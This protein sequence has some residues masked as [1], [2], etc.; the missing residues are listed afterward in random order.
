MP[1]L[2]FN[3]AVAMLGVAAFAAGC[4][5]SGSDSD[6]SGRVPGSDLP[7]SA[8][9][10]TSGLISY[11]NQLIAASDDTS[12]P[13]LVGDVVLPTDDTAEPVN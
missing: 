13:V 6:S 12:E 9:Q 8:L 11:L 4:G 5:S 10:S 3:I 1:K 2:K 7:G